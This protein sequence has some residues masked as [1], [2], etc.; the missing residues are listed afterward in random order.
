[1]ALVSLVAVH[2]HVDAAEGA[3]TFLKRPDAWFAGEEARQI[4]DNILSYQSDLG[5]WPKNMDNTVAKFT[6]DLQTLKPTFDN[7]ATTDELRFLARR[8]LAVKDERCRQAFQRGFD[9]ILKAQHPTGGWPQFYPPGTK[10]HRHIT[11]NDDTMVR[12][13][14]FL[15]ETYTSETY[16]FVASDCRMPPVVPLIAVSSAS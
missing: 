11:F 14:Q 1:M 4:V 16:A 2:A 3:H 6:G 9:Y 15:R 8:Y 10:Y 13:M 12:L 5:G 7:G